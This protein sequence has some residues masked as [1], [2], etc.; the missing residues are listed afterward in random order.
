MSL[1][2]WGRCLAG[3]VL[4][5]ASHTVGFPAGLALRRTAKGYMGPRVRQLSVGWHGCGPE[6]W[7]VVAESSS[8]SLYCCPYPRA[9][10]G[11]WLG[12]PDCEPGD[13]LGPHP[14]TLPCEKSV[15][16]TSRR[17]PFPGNPELVAAQGRATCTQPRIAGLVPPH[18]GPGPECGPR[19][20]PHNPQHPTAA[21]CV[22]LGT[23][24]VLGLPLLPHAGPGPC[25]PSSVHGQ[26]SRRLFSSF[27]VPPAAS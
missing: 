7:A 6:P 9:D 26:S 13:L 3:G 10:P 12:T 20:C 18:G 21:T 14:S 11:P 22:L 16:F 4:A 8:S 19:L 15:T 27:P 17:L 23:V 24:G 25:T 2:S 5:P 1:A